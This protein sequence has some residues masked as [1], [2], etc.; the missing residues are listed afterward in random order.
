[1]RRLCLVAAISIAGC[2]SHPSMPA[3]PAPPQASSCAFT[4]SCPD[5]F[6]CVGSGLCAPRCTTSCDCSGGREC[7]ALP[8]HCKSG[9]SC[10]MIIDQDF[11]VA[12]GSA[13]FDAGTLPPNTFVCDGP[14]GCVQVESACASNWSQLPSPLTLPWS[15]GLSCDGLLVLNKQEAESAERYYFLADSGAL[16]ASVTYGTANGPTAQCNEGLTTFTPPDCSLDG[17]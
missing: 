2:G 10:P 16:L 1:M 15:V 7:E 6:Q 17:G 14:I 4:G 11:C 9:D 8:M 13:W 5:G 12:P 3:C